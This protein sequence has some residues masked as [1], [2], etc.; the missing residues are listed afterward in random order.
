MDNPTANS[1]NPEPTTT[2]N[3]NNRNRKSDNKVTKDNTKFLNK[4]NQQFQQQL[5]QTLLRRLKITDPTSVDEVHLYAN[6]IPS[7]IPISFRGV[8]AFVQQLWLKMRSIG[9]RPFGNLDTPQNEAKFIKFCLLVCDVKLCY[10]QMNVMSRPPYPLTS[11]TLYT[12]MQ[13]RQLSS[14]T[15]KVPYALAYLFESIGLFA[16]DQQPVVPVLATTSPDV[17][18]AAVNYSYQAIRTLVLACQNYLPINNQ[19]IA[20]AMAMGDL[21]NFEWERHIDPPVPE[22]PPPVERARLTAATVE[23]WNNENIPDLISLFLQVVSSM[24]SKKDFIIHE[25]ITTGQ[26]SSVQCVRFPDDFDRD[27]VSTEF[28]INV[29]IPE[30]DKKLSGAF[31]LGYEFSIEKF[32]RYSTSVHD[33]LYRGSLSQTECR[34]A[35]IN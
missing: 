26:G 21:P 20:V 7:R 15:V 8:P 3:S 16:I 31:Q 25:D 10:A 4:K 33:C 22:G 30:Y 28:Y 27:E 18:S 34:G 9:T 5:Q 32:S 23:F 1:A 12:E 24:E 19:V 17:L 29:N 11:Q 2:S 13:L 14:A 6:V 35:V